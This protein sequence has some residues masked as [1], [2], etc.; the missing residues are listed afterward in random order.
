MD[1]WAYG[2]TPG[3][4]SSVVAAHPFILGGITV[5]LLFASTWVLHLSWGISDIL[6]SLPGAYGNGVEKHFFVR[7]CVG[8]ALIRG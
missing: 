4:L 2:L 5:V 6:E 1:C 8:L 7:L 3:P